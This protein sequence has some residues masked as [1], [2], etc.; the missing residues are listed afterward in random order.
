MQASPAQ[1]LVSAIS[2]GLKLA[3]PILPT[4]PTDGSKPTATPSVLINPPISNPPPQAMD[5]IINPPVEKD[6]SPELPLADKVAVVL[7]Y[8]DGKR[9]QVLA[10]PEKAEQYLSQLPTG[11]LLVMTVPPA[12]LMGHH[13]SPLDPSQMPK[14]NVI[15]TS[16][17]SITST[18]NWPAP[19]AYNK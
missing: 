5:P 11:V 15:I 13:P 17:G 14:G 7:Q 9:T 8:P 18:I 3:I 1:K 6:L 4:P 12:S 16:S 19:P 10:A 2:N